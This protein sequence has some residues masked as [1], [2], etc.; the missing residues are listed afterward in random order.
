MD[1][2]ELYKV[3]KG[4]TLDQLRAELEKYFNTPEGE[5]A[6]DEAPPWMLYTVQSN[7]EVVRHKKTAALIVDLLIEEFKLQEVMNPTDKAGGL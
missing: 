1:R 7:N 5:A 6:L 2:T 4:K 3:A